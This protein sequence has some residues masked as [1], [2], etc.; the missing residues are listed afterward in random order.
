MEFCPSANFSFGSIQ[1]ILMKF[2][3]KNY[4]EIRGA[5]FI[6]VSILVHKNKYIVMIFKCCVV[7]QV[8]P[9]VLEDHPLDAEHEGTTIFRNVR[10][11]L[12]RQRSIK[13]QNTRSSAAVLWYSQISR[14]L[15]QY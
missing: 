8:V 3:L 1:Q 12:A 10:N 4:T 9:V 11:Y 7:E 15:L 6:L 14:N 13:Y 5:K 2:A